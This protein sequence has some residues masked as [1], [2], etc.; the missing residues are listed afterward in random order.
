[1]FLV[2]GVGLFCLFI[3]LRKGTGKGENSVIGLSVLLYSYASRTSVI[4]MDCW[5][6][7]SGQ[8]QGLM[9]PLHSD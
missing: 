7:G 1:M 4:V 9:F 8:E 5:G 2:L 3:C 6:W